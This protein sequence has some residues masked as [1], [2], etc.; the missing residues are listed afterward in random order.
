MGSRAGEDQLRSVA[1]L[2]RSRGVQWR[3]GYVCTPD[4]SRGSGREATS[5]E[6]GRT[7][8]EYALEA[9]RKGTTAVA[10]KGDN[11][12]VLGVE[13]KS[14]AKLQ[15]PTAAGPTGQGMNQSGIESF[16]KTRRHKARPG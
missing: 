7:Q 14:N 9:V 11:V 12:I 16:F 1:A 13:K 3:S 5:S 15:V 6:G 8:V 4:V 2:R 10:V